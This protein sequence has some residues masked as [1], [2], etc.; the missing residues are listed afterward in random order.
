MKSAPKAQR[1]KLNSCCSSA[2][3]GTDWKKTPKVRLSEIHQEQPVWLTEVKQSEPGPFFPCIYHLKEDVLYLLKCYYSHSCSIFHPK[4]LSP[5]LSPLPHDP[6]PTSY[7]LKSHYLWD[8]GQVGLHN[9]SEDC[10]LHI[11]NHNQLCNIPLLLQWVLSFD[12]RQHQNFF[13]KW[14]MCLYTF[15]KRFWVLWWQRWCPAL[16]VF[17]VVIHT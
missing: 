1:E 4:H 12:E 17:F 14:F 10:F 13:S 5:S 6:P 2:A 11:H 15:T 16:S 8:E 7:L 9:L 3:Q